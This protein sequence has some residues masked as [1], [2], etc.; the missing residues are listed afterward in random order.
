MFAMQ[1]SPFSLKCELIFTHWEE[2][3]HIVAQYHFTDL[4][5]FPYTGD[6]GSDA[7]RLAQTAT[8]QIGNHFLWFSSESQHTGV[9]RA[10][11]LSVIDFFLQK[12][13][14]GASKR[15]YFLDMSY[16]Q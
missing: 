11:L 5:I 12:K 15:N 3:S 2:K 13:P 10:F 8:R 7:K 6:R 1:V 4:F 14:N 9:E 16:I